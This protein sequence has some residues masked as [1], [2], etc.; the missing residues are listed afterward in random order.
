MARQLPEAFGL[1]CRRLIL[2][3]DGEPSVCALK[4][5]A[6][7][8]LAGLR[9]PPVGDHQANG[10][11]EC[12][13]RVVKRQVRVLPHALEEHMGP[14]RDGHPILRWLPT[15]AAD[16]ISRCRIGRDG[17]TAGQRRTGRPWK[18]L[19]AEFGERVITLSGSSSVR[20]L[21]GRN[22]SSSPT[23]TSATTRAPAHS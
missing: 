21:V 4:V 12:A 9:D 10:D 7:V 1:Q 17:L 23:I 16:A 5:A 14:I 18:K 6:T 3:S 22:R 15:A 2:Q 20:L 8:R 13:V 11:A 19:I